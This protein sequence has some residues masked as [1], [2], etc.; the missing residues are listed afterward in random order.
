MDFFEGPLADPGDGIDNDKDGVIDEAGEE[1]IMSKFVYYN[2]DFSLIGNPENAT[3]YYNYL[4][5]FWKD[6]TQFQYGGNAHNTGGHVCDFMFPGD[7][8]PDGFGSGMQPQAPWSEVTVG[9]TP[10]DRRMMQS[11]GPFTLQP[12]AVNYI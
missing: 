11:A 4:A 7:T 9:N 6:G 1:I 12:G 5:G 10:D 3:H 8:G 2:N